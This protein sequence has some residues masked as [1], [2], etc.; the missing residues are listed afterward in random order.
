VSTPSSAPPTAATLVTGAGGCI[1]AWTIRQ[2]VGEGVPVVA[3]DLQPEARRLALLIDEEEIEQVTWAVADVTDLP[4]LERVFEAHSIGS[5]IH[6]AALQAPF[7]RAD[8]PLGAEVNVVGTVNLLEAIAERGEEIGPFVYASSVAAADGD[9]GDHPATIYGVY[10]RACEGIA[11]VYRR[12]RGIAS[13][14]LRPHTVYGPGR[15]QGVTSA[16]TVAMLA[17]ATGAPFEIPFTGRLTMQYAPD[18]AAAFVAASRATGYSGAGVFDLPG[19]TVDVSA[20][21]DAIAAAA[22][23]AEIAATGPPLVFPPD[24]NPSPDAPFAHALAPTP[25]GD[26][27]SDALARF[28]E[29][30]AR[31][32]VARPSA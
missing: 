3:V 23:G 14:G 20:V 11:D 32:L 24:V 4:A 27:V 6:L 5:V 18:V 9:H 30:H 31:G 2:L 26:G 28:R 19:E 8:P 13:I 10:K 1:G 7:C 15:D 16:P 21:I 17:A 22:P 12:E 29:L 25:L